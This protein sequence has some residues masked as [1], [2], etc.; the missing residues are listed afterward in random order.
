MAGAAHRAPI[1]PIAGTGTVRKGSVCLCG[2]GCLSCCL[3]A[4]D[5]I[6]KKQHSQEWDEDD[7]EETFHEL[8]IG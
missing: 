5:A 3:L 4:W 2:L 6:Q 7:E 8:T 1:S